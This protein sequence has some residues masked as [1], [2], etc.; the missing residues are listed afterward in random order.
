MWF[1]KG[2]ISTVQEGISTSSTWFHLMEFRGAGGGG[3]RGGE[4]G[5]EGVGVGRGKRGTRSDVVNVRMFSEDSF[6]I[7]NVFI[8]VPK[9]IV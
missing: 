1:N 3:E 2:E 6:C 7:T 8:E 5:V 9:R 4:G